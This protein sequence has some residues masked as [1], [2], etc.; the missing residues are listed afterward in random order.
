MAADSVSGDCD[1]CVIES[2]AWSPTITRHPPT[3]TVD[4]P[5]TT[6]KGTGGKG[7]ASGSLQNKGCE[8]N[9]SKQDPWLRIP[10]PNGPNGKEK[11]K[12]KR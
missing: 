2:L 4:V 10:L 9:D 12:K 8:Q 3:R 7:L 6:A 5:K 1:P 11:K